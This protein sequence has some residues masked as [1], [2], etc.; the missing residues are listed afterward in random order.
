MIKKI[1]FV[2]MLLSIAGVLSAQGDTTNLNLEDPVQSECKNGSGI[3]IFM[4]NIMV[5]LLNLGPIVAV[6]GFVTAG[7]IYVYANVFVTADQ[8]GRYH[9]LATNIAVGA[10]ILA[11][12]V[13]GAG[14][15]TKAGMTF[16][17][18]GTTA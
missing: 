12:I 6:L 10:I 11:A 3:E 17:E 14:F 5:T 1:M 13:G 8:R 16:L 18:P 9:T 15:L 7:V 4:C 2:F